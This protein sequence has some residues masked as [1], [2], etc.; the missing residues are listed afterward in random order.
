[1]FLFNLRSAVRAYSRFIYQNCTTALF[2]FHDIHILIRFVLKTITYVKTYDKGKT[3]IK[4]QFDNQEMILKISGHAGYAEK[5]SDIVCAAVT[6]LAG[7]LHTG[8]R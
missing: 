8:I 2:A 6:A 5:G 1:M 7:T 4:I 3:M